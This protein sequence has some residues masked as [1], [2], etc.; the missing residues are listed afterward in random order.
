MMTDKKSISMPR[1]L[2]EEPK[3]KS[4]QSVLKM[5]SKTSGIMFVVT[6]SGLEVNGYYTG[7]Q[8][9]PST[10]G[11]LREPLY[12]SWDELEKV[13]LGLSNRK[14]NKTK[15]EKYFDQ[16]PDEKYL[17]TLPVVHINGNKYYIDTEKRERRPVINPRQVVKF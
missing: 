10:Y 7:I 4:K 16:E 2:Y 12:I 6:E 5:G 3:T 13:R 14:S 9:N 15:N 8:K 1:P 17:D 11:N